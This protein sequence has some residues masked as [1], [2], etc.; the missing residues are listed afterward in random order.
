MKKITYLFLL[1]LVTGW[2]YG[3]TCEQDFWE[4]GEDIDPVVL[5]VNASDLTCAVGT[6]NSITISY[7]YLDWDDWES[8]CGEYFTFEMNL[9]GVVTTVCT[10]DLIDMDITGFTSLTIT[11]VDLDDD[12]DYVYIE[13]SI[14]VD[15]TATAVPACTAIMAPDTNSMDAYNGLIEWDEVP[16]ALGYKISLGTTATG[17]DVLDAFDVGD[18]TDY[19]V[20]G[21]LT[22]GTQY[23]LSVIPYNALGD[24]TGC[25][26]HQFT[27]PVLPPPATNDECSTAIALTVNANYSC[28]SITAGNNMGATASP[29]DDDDVSG[30]PNNDVWFSFVAT[31]TEHRVVLTDIVAVTGSSTDM[32][33]AVYNGANGCDDLVFTATSDPNT[34]NLTGL[35]V[36]HTYYVRVYGWGS[37]ATNSNLFKV[38]IGTAPLVPVPVPA[39]DT[40]ATATAT[41]LPYTQTLDAT[42][43]TNDGGFVLTCTSSSGMN[44]GVWYTV[45]GNG[46]NITITI[47]NVIGWDPELGIY[48][49]DC[50]SLTCVAARDSGGDSGNETYTIAN[51]VID[52]TYYINVGHYSGS[53]N[54]PEGPFTI[55]V[56]T[57]LSTSSFNL[58][59]LKAYPNPVKDVLMLTYDQ[60]ITNVSVF[61]LLGQQVINKSL[62]TTDAQVDMS[63]LPQGTYLVKVAADNQVK[64]IKVVKQ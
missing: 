4:E 40:C 8:A 1:L 21:T 18:E 45:A 31:S 27:V 24:A 62:N 14:E 20:P 29:Q 7:A 53:T 61:N 26:I 41:T 2:S 60:N 56:T 50:G 25:T 38:C 9:D 58:A 55:N 59:S 64:T 44:D 12:G 43:A 42:S 35:T 13:L 47:S 11:S 48:R 6:I 51:S 5:T 32:G 15:Y 36:D 49:G 54:N 52:T 23:F 46:A 28:G 33:M 57:A 34:L 37:N 10:D 30:T 39:N 19:D 17:T 16:G 3:Q 22:Q 63:A